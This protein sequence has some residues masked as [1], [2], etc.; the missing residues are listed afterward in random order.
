MPWWVCAREKSGKYANGLT[1]AEE[2][3]GDTRLKRGEESRGEKGARKKQS[4][5]KQKK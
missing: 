3:I 2:K 5:K 1:D 4:R